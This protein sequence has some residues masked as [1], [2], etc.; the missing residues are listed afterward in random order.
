VPERISVIKVKFNY[1]GP[2][3]C[4][5][6]PELLAHFASLL[7]LTLSPAIWGRGGLLL[8]VIPPHPNPLPQEFGLS[9]F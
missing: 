1:G 6:S 3:S 2:L 7:S 5:L 4:P 8:R 9:L